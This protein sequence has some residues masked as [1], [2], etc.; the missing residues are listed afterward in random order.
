MAAEVPIFVELDKSGAEWVVFAY[1]SGDQRMIDVVER[2]IS[3]HPVTGSL[4]SGAPEELIKEEDKKLGHETD[5]TVLR[6]MRRQLFPE[7]VQRGF[8]LPANM[9]IRQMGKRSNHGLNYDLGYKSFA[10]LY[11][12]TEGDARRVHAGYRRAYPGVERAHK[13]I[14]MDLKENDRILINAFGR[15]YHFLGR[16]GDELWK[17]AYSFHPQSTVGDLVNR[18]MKLLYWDDNVPDLELMQQIHDSLLSQMWIVP[19]REGFVNAAKQILIW[20]EH[21]NPTMEYSGRSF[22]I[23]SEIKAGINWGQ[24]SKDPEFGIN[25]GGMKEVVL[26]DDPEILGERLHERFEEILY[27]GEALAG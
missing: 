5:A 19:N 13:K 22:Q 14:V 24:Y 15:K 20:R 9:T 4:I 11:G 6:D 7:L 10:I 23:A 18:G 16:W 27:H 1:F 8:F 26:H 3:P 2:G 25:E 17:R 12:L 21:F